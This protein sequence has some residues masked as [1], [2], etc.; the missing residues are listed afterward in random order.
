MKLGMYIM[1]PDP[2]SKAHFINPSYQSVSLSVSPYNCQQWLGTH[3]IAAINAHATVEE[4]LDVL[5]S[6]WS[7]SYQS[8]VGD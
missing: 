3:V 1:A 7:V 2:I 4:L 6:M 5:F 8:K